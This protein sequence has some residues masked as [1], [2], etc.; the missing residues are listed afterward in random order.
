MISYPAKFSPEPEGGFTVTFR[1]VPEAITWDD[2]KESAFNMARD[3]LA[4]ALWYRHETGRDIPTASA[5]GVDEEPVGLAPLH[6]IK[7]SL[8]AAL[9]EQGIGKRELA[10]RLGIH[11]P[12]V[13][14][15][16][17]PDHESKLGSLERALAAVGQRL[18][19]AVCRAA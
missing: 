8:A 13:D 2:D 6:A 19:I 14:R 5:I 12:Q 16:L 11:P 17:D 3:A 15:L 9:R 18:E 10:R 1:D 7:L 4:L